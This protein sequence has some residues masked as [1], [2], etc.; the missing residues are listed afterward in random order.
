[1]KSAGFIH[2]KAIFT[3]RIITSGPNYKLMKIIG[4]KWLFAIMFGII[5]I[6]SVFGYTITFS[7]VGKGTYGNQISSP[8]TTL[9]YPDDWN[10]DTSGNFDVILNNMLA[11]DINIYKMTIW[12]DSTKSIYE[13]THPIVVDAGG[14]KTLLSSETSLNLGPREEG[15]RYSINIEIF[16]TP[17]DY[18]HTETGKLTGIVGP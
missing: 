15:T 1:M 3:Q 2:K 8:F 14:N 17:G 7:N 16:Y 12:W 4:R 13:P 10:I 11:S 6:L 18:N 5:G 9:G